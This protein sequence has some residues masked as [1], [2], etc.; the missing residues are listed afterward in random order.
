MR[1]LRL[2]G[3]L[4]LL[5]LL[6]VP[7]AFGGLIYTSGQADGMAGRDWWSSPAYSWVV[8]NAQTVDVIHD[9]ASK[10]LYRGVVIFDISS[11]FGM[12]L[13]P[14]SATFNFF[15]FGFS[16]VHLGFMNA[17]G[18]AVTTD[19]TGAFGT[20]VA[21]LGS[22]QGWRSYDVTSNL[23]GSIDSLNQYVAFVFMADNG[24]GG[25][26][27]ASEDEGQRGAYL[28]IEGGG[29]EIPEPASMALL[30]LGLGALAVG[31]RWRARRRAA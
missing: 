22:E 25:Q 12:T 17:F 18:P 28:S 16:G 24:G 20:H 21:S 8:D 7:C 26:L 15:S 4:S 29:E 6:G 19:Y 30:A 9:G 14:G 5:L 13:A 10:Y 31:R 2:L 27:A 11:L 1:K 23:Q 3:V